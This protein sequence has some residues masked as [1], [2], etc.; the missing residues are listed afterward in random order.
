[1]ETSTSVN[2]PTGATMTLN[3]SL[4]AR[5]TS[6]FLPLGAP[7]ISSTVHCPSPGDKAGDR[8]WMHIAVDPHDFECYGLPFADHDGPGRPL[9]GHDLPP[10]VRVRRGFSVPLARRQRRRWKG[11]LVLL[12]PPL[13]SM[14]AI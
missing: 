12:S 4:M 7:A 14:V 2:G 5:C 8:R 1:M 10:S 11:L 6:T 9:I 3:S 13:G